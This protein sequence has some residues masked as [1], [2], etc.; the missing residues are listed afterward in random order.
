MSAIWGIIDKTIDPAQTALMRNHYEKHCKIDRFDE[1][2]TDR[3][4]MGCGLQFFTPEASAEQLPISFHDGRYMMTA[5]VVLDNRK[6]LISDLETSCPDLAIPQNNN[7]IIA[8]GQ[9]LQRAFEVWG[10]NFVKHLKGLF[11]IAV[12]DTEKEELFLCTDQLSNRCLY[13]Y[14]AD[15]RV[16]F[17]TRIT[18][19]RLLHPEI[20]PDRLYYKDYLI[21]PGLFPNFSSEDTPWSGVKM[22]EAGTYVLI[23]PEWT[24]KTEYWRPENIKVSGNIKNAA[25]QFLDTYKIAVHRALRTSGEVGIAL[26]SGCDS[27]SVA[28]LAARKLAN[29]EKQLYSYTYIPHYKTKSRYYEVTDETEGVKA[30]G[31]MYPNIEM[32]FSDQDGRDFT[33]SIPEI[34]ETLEIP[35]KAFINLSSLTEIY[36]AACRE[37]CRVF[38]TGQCGN[39]TVS[40]GYADDIL[41][42]LYRKKRPFRWLR[43][44]SEYCKKAGYSRKKHFRYLWKSYRTAK[45]IKKDPIIDLSLLNSFLDREI[46]EEYDLKKRLPEGIMYTTEYYPSDEAT[47]RASLY[48]KCIY[49]YLGVMDTKMS[50]K[51]GLLLRDPTRD[52]DLLSFCNSVPYEYFAWNGSQRYFIREVMKDY[53]PKAITAF[54]ARVGI[55]NADWLVRLDADAERVRK[56]EVSAVKDAPSWIKSDEIRAYIE[57][58][59]HIEEKNRSLELDLCIILSFMSFLHS[60]PLSS[61]VKKG[62]IIVT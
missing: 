20:K 3:C 58:H 49:S 55:Q 29:E 14:K 61:V 46:L 7:P 36:E 32:H 30:I 26:S 8:D 35:Y 43:L 19:I 39:S 1:I 10:Y 33:D 42:D 9:L 6:E 48:S 59:P 52:M 31:R 47:N 4:Y 44:Y 24:K 53:L 40:Y 23:G 11:S 60:D 17:S 57:A 34:T 54:H 5:D 21:S 62:N 16:V 38:L 50:L 27:S 28:A 13:Y 18:P 37:G 45:R 51:Y 2:Q 15:N 56:L 41:Y 12:F 25:E 22:L